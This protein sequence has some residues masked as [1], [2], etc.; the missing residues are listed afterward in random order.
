M[1]TVKYKK[2]NKYSIFRIKIINKSLIVSKEED[3]RG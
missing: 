1:K 2:I 3:M